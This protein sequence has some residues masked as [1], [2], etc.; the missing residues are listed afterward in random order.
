MEN[1]QIFN[2]PVTDIIKSRR[3]VRTYK[4]EELSGELKDKLKKYAD[5]IKGPFE[6]KVRLVLIDDADIAQKS[7]GKI[8]TY[9]IIKGAKAYIAAV[10][11]KEGKNS[12]EQ[13]GYELEKLIIFATSLNLGTCWLGGTFKKSEFANL[14]DIRG[15]EIM[16]IVT[17]V[18]YIAN[19]KSMVES[20]MRLA[21]GSNNRKPWK[22]LFFNESF[23]SPLQEKDAGGYAEALEMLRL[24]PSASNKQP[25]RV[26]KQGSTYHFYLN[27]TKGYGSALGFN[28]QKIDMGIGMCHF[29]LTA[30]EAGIK[31][32]WTIN[33]DM[34]KNNENEEMQY[35]VSWV[36]K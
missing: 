28:I 36:E 33:N 2:R 7:N 32:M 31:G 9:G 13:L 10:T 27:S 35:I 1:N 30:N 20:F 5:E 25:W 4:P 22:E 29:E 16:P 11:E 19:N 12:L 34:L 15:N 8:G 17:P 14:V 24:A 23:N 18:G 21:A 26:L 6:S 3:S